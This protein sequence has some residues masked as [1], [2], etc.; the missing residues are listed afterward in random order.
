MK[1]GHQ[2]KAN[3][4]AWN[5]VAPLFRG[6][7]A[8]PKWGPFSVGINDKSLIGPI[9]NKTFLEIGC[10]SGHSI[11][12]LVGRGAKKVYGIDLSHTQIEFARSLNKKAISKGKVELFEVPMEQK[13]KIGPVDTVFSIYGIGWTLNPKRLLRNIR[14]YLKP[15]GRFVWS[16]DHSIFSDVEHRK[17][18]LVIKHSYHDESEIFV[19]DW[20][21]SKG[22]YITYRKTATWFQPLSDNGL[23][24]IRYLEPRP[25]RIPE[26]IKD[27]KRY[28]STFKA[29][30]IPATIIFVCRK[31]K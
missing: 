5:I 15:G 14:S 22:A 9:K 12:Y 21:G 19:K 10:G 26:K 13:L 18:K 20:R 4:Q 17:G 11:R 31:L 7:S 28:Y 25:V 30:M 24:V 6:G 27:P 3:K 8:L 23:S 16:W 2:L 1:K 29:K